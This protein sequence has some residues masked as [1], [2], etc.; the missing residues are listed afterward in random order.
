MLMLIDNLVTRSRSKER[1][2][3]D[4]PLTGEFLV[5]SVK[6]SETKETVV[7]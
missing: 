4:K 1:G 6:N 3:S 2:V 5:D 7:E